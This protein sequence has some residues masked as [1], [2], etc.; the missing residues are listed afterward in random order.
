MARLCRGDPESAEAYLDLAALALD[1]EAP[2]RLVTELWLAMLHLIRQP[3]ASA[4]ADCRSLAE[5][6]QG[7]GGQAVGA[8][9]AGAALAGARQRAAVPLGARRRRRRADVGSITS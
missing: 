7:I 9:G 1:D 6:A 3:D 5:R 4:T 8:P 2:D